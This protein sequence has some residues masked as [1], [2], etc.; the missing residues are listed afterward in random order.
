[1]SGACTIAADAGAVRAMLGAVGCNTRDFAHRGFEALTGGQAFQSGLTAVLTVYVALIGYRLLF[2]PDG[3]RLSD[4]PRMALKIGAVLALITSW[5]L[6]ET[7]VF[8]VAAKAPAEIAELISLGQGGDRQDLADPVGRLQVAY[9]QLSVSAF[10][11]G[12][13]AAAS[14]QGAAQSGPPTVAPLAIPASTEADGGKAEAAARLAA[15]QQAAARA[16]T[17]ASGA[18]LTVDAG[19]LAVTALLVGVLSAIGPIFITLFLFRQ[20]RGFF[21][22]WVRALTAAALASMS[23]WVLILLMLNVLEPW[24]VS[25]AQQ[26]ELKQL[27]ASTAM[28]AASIVFVFTSAQLAMAAS[29]AVVAFGFRLGSEP[30]APSGAAVNGSSAGAAEAGPPV[31]MLSRPGLLADQLRRFDQVFESRSRSAAAG[32]AASSM[33][34]V[35]SDPSV[36]PGRL[37]SGY[38][39]S[40]L[41]RDHLGRREDR[42]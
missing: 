3:A 2:A 13:T 31:E 4:G 30:R 25:L 34:L 19:M 5:S 41:S 9:D 29:G 33:R 21:E 36:T 6:F 26:R 38:R 11:F 35:A 17:A 20:T 24:L 8:D 18:V 42:R 12:A 16:L 7:L 1:M 14:A 40:E 23:A 32:A 10:A 22:G 28:T 15:R 37:D 39:R 27:D